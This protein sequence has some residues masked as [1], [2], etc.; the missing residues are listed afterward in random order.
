MSDDPLV[1]WAVWRSLDGASGSRAAGRPTAAEVLDDW[2][3]RRPPPGDLMAEL[4]ALYQANT[5]TR[6]DGEPRVVLHPKFGSG[7]STVPALWVD[8]DDDAPDLKRPKKPDAKG[9]ALLAMVR[10]LMDGAEPPP[11]PRRL[12]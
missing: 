7:N 6:Q 4:Q 5:S 10:R 11:L 2:R 1:L 12:L 3:R 8:Q 9:D